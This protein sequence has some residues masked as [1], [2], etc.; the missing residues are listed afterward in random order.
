MNTLNNFI[1]TKKYFFKISSS[2]NLIV[3]VKSVAA[4][5]LNVPRLYLLWGTID[6]KYTSQRYILSGIQSKQREGV[7]ACGNTG[8]LRLGGWGGRGITLTANIKQPPT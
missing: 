4:K 3:Y 7:C 1:F 2:S 5:V 8:V 6:G